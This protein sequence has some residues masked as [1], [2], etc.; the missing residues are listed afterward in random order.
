VLLLLLTGLAVVL[1]LPATADSVFVDLFTAESLGNYH[2]Q[3]NRSEG[4]SQF[5]R[6]LLGDGLGSGWVREGSPISYQHVFAPDT[7]VTS[8]SNAWLNI[9]LMDDYLSDLSCSGFINCQLDSETA[10]IQIFDGVS[11]N[12]FDQGSPSSFP[13][14]FVFGSV[15]GSI[16]SLGDSLL[17][18]IF[19]DT[20]DF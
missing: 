20:G 1:A 18:T 8:V 4:E 15:A 13:G 10:R 16:Q 3:G 17:V 2:I 19:A 14:T 9:W 7:T 12:T 11:D 5:D 6:D